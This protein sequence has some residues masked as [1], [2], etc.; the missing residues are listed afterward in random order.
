MDFS[1]GS[2]GNGDV[3]GIFWHPHFLWCG[4]VI[5]F[6]SKCNPFRLNSPNGAESVGC[7]VRY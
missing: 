3:S 1:S 7:L 5:V 6:L 4:G 2:L